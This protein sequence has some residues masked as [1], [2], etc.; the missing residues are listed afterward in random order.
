MFCF[1]YCSPARNPEFSAILQY[2]FL[3]DRHVVFTDRHVVFL[4]C[5]P[6][7]NP[8]VSAI[9]KVFRES[10]APDYHTLCGLRVPRSQVR[11]H[12]AVR[13]NVRVCA[14]VGECAYVG[15]CSYS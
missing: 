3:I 12:M 9:L 1:L 6:A 7:R 5:S 10:N 15:E 14:F 2:L 8:E 11:A 13:A 4:Y